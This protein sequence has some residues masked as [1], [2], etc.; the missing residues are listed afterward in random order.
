VTLEALNPEPSDADEILE[1][2][3]RQLL[4]P[5]TKALLEHAGGRMIE[6]R[7]TANKGRV[8]RRP[9]VLIDSGPLEMVTP[10]VVRSDEE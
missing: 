5:T 9:A 1:A 6:V 2:W 3:V 4:A 8:R 10:D 7:L